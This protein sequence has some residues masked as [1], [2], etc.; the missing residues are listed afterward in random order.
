[1]PRKPKKYH[2]VYRTTCN[3]TNKYYIGMHSSNELNDGY[4]GSGKILRRSVRKYGKTNHRFEILEFCDTPEELPL[5]EAKIVNIELL[6]DP[7]CINLRLGG[8]GNTGGP[9]TGGWK[10]PPMTESHRQNLKAALQ[11][12]KPHT[13]ETKRKM[14]ESHKGLTRSEEHKLHNREALKKSETFQNKMKSPEHRELMS[15]RMKEFHQ[16]RKEAG[17]PNKGGWCKTPA[18]HTGLPVNK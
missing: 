6:K 3:I 1:M 5:L 8:S 4:L 9:K 17:L 12:K 13:E 11:N 7:L 2:Y 14:S 15:K 10:M 16:R 18:N